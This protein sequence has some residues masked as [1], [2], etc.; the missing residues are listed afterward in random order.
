MTIHNAV[1][2]VEGDITYYS[3]F[4]SDLDALKARIEQRLQRFRGEWAFD[5][6]VGVIRMPDD[7]RKPP[8][9]SVWATWIRRDLE[10]CPGVDRVTTLTVGFNP[11][12]GLLTASGTIIAQDDQLPVV[13][14]L[15][16]SITGIGNVPPS[17]SMLTDVP[18]PTW[19]L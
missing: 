7:T 9:P 2:L 3:G 12:T 10:A 8:Q 16:S 6:G 19:V 5:R 14:T 11:T 15:P 4:L 1:Q 13:I 17:V 18:S